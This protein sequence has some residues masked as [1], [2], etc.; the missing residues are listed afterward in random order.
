MRRAV[1]VLLAA[2][3]PCFGCAHTQPVPGGQ[4]VTRYRTVAA[5]SHGAREKYVRENP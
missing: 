1:V 4:T 2:G 3:A 5:A